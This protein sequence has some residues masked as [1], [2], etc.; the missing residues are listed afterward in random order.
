MEQEV[1]S[2]ILKSSVVGGV[3]VGVLLTPIV[4]FFYP[5]FGFNFVLRLPFGA[6][7]LSATLGVLGGYLI[8]KARISRYDNQKEVGETVIVDL[9]VVNK[10]L[11]KVDLL[12][13]AIAAVIFSVIKKDYFSCFEMGCMFRFV[14]V[15]FAA[16]IGAVGS[17]F[18][19][20]MLQIFP[21]LKAR[22]LRNIGL[23][24]ILSFI[25]IF[26]IILIFT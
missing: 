21:K 5:Y 10:N 1:Q 7:I 13:T 14:V 2:K 6:L 22:G 20:F 4:S 8:G 11:L 24:F 18:L 15:G 26:L 9:P 19:A 16:I 3:I 23:I 25:E 12:I 17:I